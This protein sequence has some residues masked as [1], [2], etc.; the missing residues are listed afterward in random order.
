MATKGK[1]G[2]DSGPNKSQAI[3]EYLAEHPEATPKDVVAGLKEKGLTVTPGLVGLVK[4]SSG[5][6]AKG[7]PKTKA[8]AK[9][10]AKAARAPRRKPNAASGTPSKSDAVRAYLAANPDASPNAVRDA[11]GAKGVKISASL[12]ASL[13]YS[14]RGR[15]GRPGGKRGPG[16]PRVASLTGDGA[17]DFTALV[18]AKRLAERLGGIDAAREALDLLAKLA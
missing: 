14:K 7:A 3:R 18:D 2:S 13:K 12:A 15:A 9:A 6:K 1:N 17:L 4:H 10:K 5:K 16:R 8:K 11:L